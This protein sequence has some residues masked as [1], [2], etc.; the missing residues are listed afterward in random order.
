MLNRE[1]IKNKNCQLIKYNW[2]DVHVLMCAI[3]IVIKLKTLENKNTIFLCS[4]IGICILDLSK[5]SVS[6]IRTSMLSTYCLSLMWKRQIFSVFYQKTGESAATIFYHK[7]VPDNTQKK[8]RDLKPLSPE[9]FGCQQGRGRT[10][11]GE[12]HNEREPKVIHGV[13]LEHL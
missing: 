8:K 5:Q 13:R 7:A 10:V 6:A 2:F 9:Q 1:K 11:T 4:N 3:G 12:Q